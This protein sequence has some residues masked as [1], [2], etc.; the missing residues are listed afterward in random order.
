MPF[1][2]SRA[3][4]VCSHSLTAAADCVSSFF[5]KT[6]DI[7]TGM[8]MMIGNNTDYS[9]EIIANEL[10]KE[11]VATVCARTIAKY[12][13]RTGRKYFRR[14]ANEKTLT[15]VCAGFTTDNSRID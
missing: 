13:K 6:A 11:K 1:R 10:R 4:C 12:G 5:V 9:I 14:Q 7:V 2:R 15:H 8:M 3:N